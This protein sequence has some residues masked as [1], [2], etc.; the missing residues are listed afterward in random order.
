MHHRNH[1]KTPRNILT[2]LALAALLVVVVPA[3]AQFGQ[4]GG[5]VWNDVDQDGAVDTNEYGY[6]NVTVRLKDAGGT[7][8][9]TR[10][11]S[12]F[13]PHGFYAFPS[14]AA[15]TYTVEVDTTTL[16]TNL[17]ATFDTDGLATLHTAVVTL[18]TD[19]LV[20]GIDFGYA[21]PGTL[22]GRLWRDEDADGV[23]DT[24]R[25]GTLSG[26][27]VRLRDSGGALVATDVTRSFG[28]VYFF[29]RLLPGVYTVEVDESTLPADLTAVYDVD[30]LS[31]PSAADVSVPVETNVFDADFGY[32]PAA[33]YEGLIGYWPLDEGVGQSSMDFSTLGHDATVLGDPVWTFGFTT[34]ALDLDG[35]G[36]AVEIPAFAEADTPPELTIAA[37]IRTDAPA[38]WRS[39]LDKR[40]AQADGYDLYVDPSGLPFLRVGNQTLTGTT[41]VNDGQ[42]RHV[43]GTYDGNTLALYVD[44]RIETSATV[45]AIAIDTTGPVLV[46]ENWARG[47]S[48]FDGI[49]DEV[50]L[51]DRGLPASQ[52]FEVFNYR[53]LNDV[54]P[55]SRQDGVPTGTLPSGT[56]QAE[57]SLFTLEDAFCRYAEVPGVAY[58]AM[59]DSFA[60]NPANG[61]HEATLTGLTDGTITTVHVRC[62][63]SA[64]NANDDDY[65]ISVNV[66][67]GGPPAPA[68]V[69]HWALDESS[70]SVAADS[71]GF[72]Y[73]GTVAGGATWTTGQVG[74]ALAFDGV[75]D[76]VTLGATPR[77]DA[78]A[79][80]TIAAWIKHPATTSWRSIVDKRDAGQDGYDVYIDT[81]GRLFLR[82]NTETLVGPYVDDDGWHHVAA[83]YDGTHLR[84]YLDGSET[85]ARL[86]GALT[87][88]TTSVL[89]LG[90]NWAVGN[91]FFAGTMDEVRIYDFGLTAAE[92][93]VL[94]TP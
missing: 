64:G 50:R 79:E 48:Y 90:E 3:A 30:G 4:I 23:L 26:V 27:T 69:G 80:L 18:Q 53:L 83:V 86:V 78:P 54:F 5:R 56:T 65:P 55:P 35:T 36:D 24:D 33:W 8:V 92:I 59:T 9:D 32:G 28:G 58:A 43:A 72:G 60:Y 74:G 84:L 41:P 63:D 25:E 66:A 57:V 37:W 7:V 67:V 15:G 52:V 31:T 93:A 89:R 19:E 20:E 45:G 70:G 16:P 68:L 49:V 40:D 38:G 94:A 44:G 88:D 1:D 82:I 46:G 61:R 21:N 6:S 75:D 17:T 39:I 77:L 42:W 81:S 51:Y 11:T 85:S 29:D 34:P 91:S 2:T 12:D 22:Q 73:D 76:A 87:I 10:Q 14:L 71:S 13:D 62:E 47:N